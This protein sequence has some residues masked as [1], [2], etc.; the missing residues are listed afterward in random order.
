MRP[1]C[2]PDERINGHSH[3]KSLFLN[4]GEL[5]PIVDGKLALGKWQSI[6]FIELDGPRNREVLL[7][8]VG[9]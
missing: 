5:I 1:D 2:N 8:F 7:Q 4:S 6:F 9:E 3:L